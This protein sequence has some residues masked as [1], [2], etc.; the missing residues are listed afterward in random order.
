[1]ALP[2]RICVQG[3]ISDLLVGSDIP[4]SSVTLHVAK[5]GLEVGTVSESEHTGPCR[6]ECLRISG[7]RGVIFLGD[8]SSFA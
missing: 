3:N 6:C 5:G 7:M 4:G 2:M 8:D 1:M